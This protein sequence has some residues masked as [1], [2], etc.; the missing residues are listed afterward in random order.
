MTVNELKREF[1]S[2]KARANRSDRYLRALRVSLD[3]FSKVTGRRAITEVTDGPLTVCLGVAPGR[4]A[5]DS[6]RVLA[7][8]VNKHCQLTV[9]LL[10]R[11][12]PGQGYDTCVH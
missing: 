1:V 5:Q 4:A 10:P 3:S 9:S 8:S 6:P 7:C 2:A 11:L 12:P